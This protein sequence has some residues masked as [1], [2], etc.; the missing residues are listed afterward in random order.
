MKLHHCSYIGLLN[1]QRILQEGE[2]NPLTFPLSRK[3]KADK[4]FPRKSAYLLHYNN[5]KGTSS[6]D[7]WHGVGHYSKPYLE[8]LNADAF[9]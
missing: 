1:L 3:V 6:K 7:C 4:G 8:F 2:T 9:E 5:I